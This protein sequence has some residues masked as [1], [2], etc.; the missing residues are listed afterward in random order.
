M[1]VRAREDVRGSGSSVSDGG[2]TV[3]LLVEFG[4]SSSQSQDTNDEPTRKK[5]N[6]GLLFRIC[7]LFVFSCIFMFF[8]IETFFF[9]MIS[10]ETQNK[11]V[12]HVK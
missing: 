1:L 8:T 10:Y 9:L 6:Q 4:I 5:H 12:V 7:R 11:T 2:D 3:T